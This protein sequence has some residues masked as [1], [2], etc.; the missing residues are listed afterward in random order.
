METDLREALL[1]RLKASKHGEL[2]SEKI[3]RLEL[4]KKK[5][6]RDWRKERKHWQPQESGEM[7]GRHRTWRKDAMSL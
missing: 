7:Q 5:K 1:L 3:K 4:A 2:L 6:E